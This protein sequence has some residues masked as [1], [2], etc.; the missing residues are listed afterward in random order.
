MEDLTATVETQID[1]DYS[2]PLLLAEV[3]L[4]AGTLRFAAINANF[5]FPAAG[6]TYI[7]KAFGFSSKKSTRDGQI[8]EM[9]LMFDNISGDMYG[10]NI[11][12]RFTGKQFILKKV[13]RGNVPTAADYRE[14]I[15]G[16]MEEPRFDKEWMTVKVINGKALD[17]RILQEYF[18]KSCN[19]M[20]GDTRCNKDGYANLAVLKAT[21]TSD[22]GTASTLIDD[23]LVQV[24]DY[25]N[26]GRIEMDIDGIIYKRKIIDF[27]AAA[28]E[29]T[30]DV[31]LHVAVGAGVDYVV[32]KG[33]PGTWEACK[34]TS[35]HGPS[36]DNKANFNG[37]IHIG[38]E[39][40]A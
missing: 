34:A 38:D 16:F 12:E 30:F 33:C 23:A 24:D 37:W 21:G 3:Y 31:P 27:D 22:G 36:S 26:F 25:W 29:L 4:D 17:R 1:A 10:Y 2:K 13:Y 28:D 11:A 15:N 8:V 5:V 20:F 39:R 32:Y 14:M 9:E 7:A 40:G 18:Q 6:N 19:N 35:A